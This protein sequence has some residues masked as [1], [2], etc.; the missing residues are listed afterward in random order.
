MGPLYN[1]LSAKSSFEW[2]PNEQTC[3]DYSKSLLTKN[4]LLVYYDPSKPIIVACVLSHLINGEERPVMFVSSTLSPAEK[5]Y[6]QLHRE[7]LAIIFGIK[8]FHKYI[9]GHKYQI[10]TDHQPLKEIFGHNK[11]TPPVA[12]ARL[13]RWAVHLSMYTYEIVYRKSKF[14]CHADALSRLPMPDSSNI[15]NIP[16]NFISSGNN[17]NIINFKTIQMETKS[18][19]IESS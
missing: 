8:K 10:Y 6:S 17:Q 19:F 13:Q 3:F 4:D 18:N 2:T 12:A 1:F 9:Y 16:I 7:A 15:E 11:S 5:N 14:M